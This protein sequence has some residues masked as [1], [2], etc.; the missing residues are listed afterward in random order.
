MFQKL[1]S[2][3]LPLFIATTFASCIMVEDHH[4]PVYYG[5]AG[6]DG[7]V[8]FGIDYDYAMPYSYWDNNPHVPNNPYFGDY[9]Q[10]H[11][12]LYD[13]EYFVN[14]YEYWYGTYET[15]QVYGEPG[16]PNGQPGADGNDT[17]LL[18][19]CNPDGFY[20]EGWEECSC[21]KTVLEDGSIQIEA[22][23]RDHQFRVIMKKTN[24]TERPSMHVPKLKNG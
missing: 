11:A 2:I 13:F 1:R 3:V 18:L 7:K 15:Y 22:K 5:P 21:Y 23:D 6:Y 17:Y 12:G 9:F 10:T 4:E 19:I 8:F 24:T 16:G 14:P 20:F